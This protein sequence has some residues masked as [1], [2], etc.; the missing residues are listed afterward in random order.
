[1][2]NFKVL[3]FAILWLATNAF[4]IRVTY[5][6]KY[7]GQKVG[8]RTQTLKIVADNKGELVL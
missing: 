3:L 1:M 4:A 7:T 8:E 5:S 2:F 6:G